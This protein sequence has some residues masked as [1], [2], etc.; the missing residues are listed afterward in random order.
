MQCNLKV[1]FLIDAFFLKLHELMHVERN[2]IVLKNL[3]LNRF[4]GQIKSGK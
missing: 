4:D 3:T 2:I 1:G